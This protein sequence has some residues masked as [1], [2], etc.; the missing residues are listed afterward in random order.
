MQKSV[1]L[2]DHISILAGVVSV[3]S[4]LGCSRK[5]AFILRELTL[6]LLPALI[7]SRKDSAAELG[8]H[9]AASLSTFDISTGG[10]S[11]G[12]TL[13]QDSKLNDGIQSFLALACEIY[14]TTLDQPGKSYI[15]NLSNAYYGELDDYESISDTCDRAMIHSFK[16]SFGDWHL[17]VEILRLCIN[18]CEA[19]PDLQGVVRFSSALLATTAS[20]MAPGIGIEPTM[21]QIPIEDQARLMS[22]ISRTVSVAR[23]VGLPRIEGEYWDEFLVRDLEVLSPTPADLPVLRQKTEL[24]VATQTSKEKKGGPFIYNPFAAKQGAAVKDLTLIHNEEAIISVS[25]QNLADIDLEIEWLRLDSNDSAVEGMV[26]NI[27]I[28]PHR[29]QTI[30]LNAMTRRLGQVTINGCIAKI[31]GCRARRFALFKAPWKGRADTKMKQIGLSAANP[32]IDRPASVGSSS[33]QAQQPS[34]IKFPIPTALIANV[35]EN[36][37]LI[38]LN[39]ASLSQLTVMVLEGE[40]K[41]FSITLENYSST[42]IDFVLF[43]FTDS[44]SD[45]L[46]SKLANK[47]LTPAEIYE[48]ELRAST[49]ETFRMIQPKNGDDVNIA[50]K[51]ELRIEAEIYGKPG[52]THGQVIITYAHFGVPRSEVGDRFYTRQLSIPLSITVHPALT[53]AHNDILPFTGDFAWR[54]NYRCNDSNKNKRSSPSREEGSKSTGK[55]SLHLPEFLKRLGRESQE[56]DN[57]LLYFDFR[58]VWLKPLSISLQV[59]EN[60]TKEANQDEP[61]KRAYTVHD[62][63]QTGSSCRVFVLLPRFGLKTSHAAIPSVSSAN[64]RQFVLSASKISPETERANRQIFWYREEILKHLRATWEEPNS[65]RHGDIDLR[66]LRLTSHMVDAVKL[67]DFVIELVLRKGFDEGG[68]AGLQQVSRSA[69]RVHTESQLSLVAR[70]TNRLSHP[71]YPLVR[72]QPSVRDQPPHLALDLSKRLAY[73]GLLQRALPVLGAGEM[74]EASIGLVFLAAGEYDVG[75]SVEE[76]RVWKPVS[77]TELGLGKDKGADT[78]DVGTLGTEASGRRVWYGR[79]PLLIDVFDDAGLDTN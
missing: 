26:Q 74:Q 69:Y 17:K 75:A 44:A 31:R 1:D 22:N 7:Q 25:L 21:F 32:V 51:G 79:D 45:L 48:A 65:G 64:Q 53:L 15:Q 16:R 9:P 63:V 61:W 33:G 10:S 38:N 35:I 2:Y 11:M 40:T 70:I 55:T 46:Q 14:G 39:T 19:L 78:G 30:T 28:F 47:S 18:I 66:N 54:G 43:S 58:N 23:Q 77:G 42:S 3:L 50:P 76:T 36:Q 59:R 67:E 27:V 41:I 24:D 57:C 29:I 52:L 6:L 12:G 37:P 8:L 73:N 72:L 20:G 60:V 49:K 34:T 56:V 62:T 71:I 13:S 4:I 5:K 68:D